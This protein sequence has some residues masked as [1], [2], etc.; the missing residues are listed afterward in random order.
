MERQDTA[1]GSAPGAVLFCPK[2]AELALVVRYDGTDYHGFQKQPADRTVQGELDRVL[3][4]VLGPG[5]TVGASRT[6]AGVHAEGQVV[7]WRGR[8]AIP[9]GRVA[10]VLN[11]RLPPAIQVVRAGWVPEGWDPRRH[12]SDKQYSYR[13]WRAAV[14]PSLDLYRMVHWEPGQLA[15]TRLQEAAGLFVGT[16]DFRAF[17]TEGSSAETTVRTIWLSRWT[18][19]Q[20]G[21]VWRYQVMGSGF[22]YRM[23]RHMVGSMLEA[24]LPGG[25]LE[26]IRAGLAH[27]EVKAGALAPPTGLVLNSI[28]FR[29]GDI[30]RGG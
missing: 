8:A 21:Q 12:T 6:D 5:H 3:G 18:M 14:P 15:W 9:L 28:R 24:A 23:V 19:E 27:P 17:R 29:D 20:D 22:L 2:G 13:V 10:V 16:H 4:Q 1:L 11:R 7:V 26:P 30:I 25:T